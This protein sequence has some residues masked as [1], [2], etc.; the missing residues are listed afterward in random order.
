M[1]KLARA[2][3][4][5]AALLAVALAGPARAARPVASLLQNPD[6]ERGLPS[7]PWMPS[8]WDTSMADL[9]TVFFGRDSFIVHSGK[10]AVNVANM[11]GAF[12]M[13]HNWSQTLLVG[14]EVWGKVATFRVWTRSNGLSGRA[15]IVVQAYSDTA[16]RMAKIWKVDRDEALKRLGIAKIDDPLL[17]LGWKRTQFDDAL[18]EWI[19]REASAYVPPGVNVI[20]VR[21]GIMGTGQVLFDDASLTFAK[22]PP[23]M[24][25][26]PGK[27]LFKEPGFEEHGL[28]WDVAIPPYEGS[29][30]VVD[31]TVAHT[32]RCSIKLADFHDGLVET[33]IGVGQPFEGRALRGKRVRL[34]CWMKGDSLKGDAFVK[35]YS[36]G[37]RTRVRQSPAAELLFGTFD[38]KPV[39]IELDIPDDAELVWA[40]CLAGAPATGTL[41]IDDASFEVV[42]PAQGALGA[43]KAPAAK[44]AAARK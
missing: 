44:A 31:S 13:A 30:V 29:K 28:S 37:L 10:W 2:A 39:S 32:G 4:A 25:P 41:W 12:P 1:P 3:L 34:S 35:I 9:P 7:H 20:F 43:T 42:G 19:P 14:P 27:N 21:C 6:F 24:K 5:A 11:S 23:P 33:R 18:T 40:N 36:Q 38:W 26:E 17:D 8:G 15:Y 22:A 16:S